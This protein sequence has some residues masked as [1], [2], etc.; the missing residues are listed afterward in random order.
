MRELI[1]QVRAGELPRRQFL[2]QMMSL[3]L[4][5]PMAATLL[6]Q[7]GPA[8]AQVLGQASPY[9]PTKRG[10][11]GPLRLLMWQAPTLLN[12]HFATGTKD[13]EGSSVFYEGL[14]RWDADGNLLPV[15]AAEIPSRD[16]GGL[17]ADFKSVVWKLKK[18]VT[19]HDGKPFT[20]DDVVFNWQY[21]SDPATAAVTAGQYR[22]LKFEKVDSHTV[23][24]VY[25][26][27]SPFWPE[28]YAVLPLIPK[29]LFAA[30]S[31]A[32]SREA[33]ANLRPV[34][35]GPYKFTEFKPGDMVRGEINTAYHQANKPHFDTV[36]LKGGGDAVS[37]AR[38]VL[39]TGEFD[40][41]WN[42]LVEDDVLKRLEAGGKGRV[43]FAQGGS[44]EALFLNY[45]DP[46]TEVDG[47]RAQAGTRHPLFSD[48]ALVKAMGLLIDRQAIQTFVFG[49]AAVATP[50]FVN[51][52]ARFRSPNLK[53]EFSIDK[54]NALL[55]AAG[56]KRGADGV[57][58][59]G[60]R[61]LKFVFQT[62]INAPRQKV[63]AIIKQAC[64]KAGIELEL[65][66]VLASIYF[67]SDVGNPDTYGKFYAD[68]QMYTTSQGRPDPERQLQ[69][70]VSWE[71]ASKAN[72]WL[73]VNLSRWRSDA[74]DA[75]YRA[76][77]GEL[78]PVKRAALCIRMNDMVCSEG[79]VQPLLF[80]AS[81]SGLGNKIQAPLNGW[82]LDLATL[83][84]WYREA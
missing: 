31:G 29:H 37:A 68:L 23:R 2:G 40:Y 76:A 82:S 5:L 59:K 60:G 16:N 79:Y 64:Q 8:Q 70:F 69:R 12:P 48:P 49:R 42:L 65:K 25:A 26:K 10:G 38:A 9:K 30:Y 66:S 13:E 17:A 58:E 1:E 47:E 81:V 32:K 84:D 63:Q 43:V 45:C 52:P 19:W 4:S 39:Q 55:D 62:S 72:K 36:E 51:S 22:D 6:M 3:G 44:T 7:A 77:E 34:G 21:A 41:A 33:P 54:A 50:N 46:A 75:A 73:G 18:G 24:V 14:A 53:P 20:A 11:G 56:Y 80:R 67:S 28:G 74:Y 35:T 27:A 57:R 78:D 15:L 71:I 83:S 61:K